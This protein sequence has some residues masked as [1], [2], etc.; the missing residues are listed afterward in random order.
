M[1]LGIES[2]AGPVGAA[3]GVADVQNPIR[4]TYFA[5]NGRREHRSHLVVFLDDVDRLGPQLGRE[6]DQVIGR[7]LLARIRRRFCREGLRLGRLLARHV[8]LRH[9]FFHDWPDRLSAR[10]IL[11]SV[12]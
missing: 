2:G 5:D 4:S 1:S 12:H 7:Y 6:I 11:R 3:G 8:A 10:G 9:G